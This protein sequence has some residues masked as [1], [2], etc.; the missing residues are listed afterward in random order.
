MKASVY[1]ILFSIIVLSGCED[2]DGPE[3]RGSENIISESRELDSFESIHIS[4]V[5]NAIIE[6]GD[7]VV[8]VQ[9]N[10]N[11]IDLINTEVRDNVLYID[12]ED[13]NY[14]DISITVSIS[15]RELT[16]LTTVGVNT[17]QIDQFND[18]A[19]FDLNIEGVGNIQMSGSAKRVAIN[20]SGSSNLE[21]FDF[22]CLH[23]E[24][25]LTGVG[26]VQITVTEE[27][28]GALSGVGNILYK[29]SP[30]I[31][32]DVTGVGNVVNSN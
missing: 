19:Q 20:S 10:D 8:S 1:A 31:D 14:D 5:I 16:A 23:C 22:T 11:I 21:A 6:Q 4:S 15:N 17:V 9:A 29:G 18:L 13:G 27:L 3:I 12:L 24:I 25:D 30:E 32:V 7:Q 26:N 2:L 28:V